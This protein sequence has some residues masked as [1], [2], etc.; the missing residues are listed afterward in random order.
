[1]KITEEESNKVI[2][3]INNDGG[4]TMDYEE[5]ILDINKKNKGGIN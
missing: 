2:I 5:K 3:S 1:M 4:K